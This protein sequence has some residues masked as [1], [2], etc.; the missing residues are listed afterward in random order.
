M[1][2]PK[3]ETHFPPVATLS[4][5]QRAEI[6]RHADLQVAQHVAGLLRERAAQANAEYRF[7]DL[8]DRHVATLVLGLLLAAGCY[9]GLAE[10]AL[11]SAARMGGAAQAQ[12]ASVVAWVGL[13]LFLPAW[14]AATVLSLRLRVMGERCWRDEVPVQLA[15][16][17][18]PRLSPRGLLL[19]GAALGAAGAGAWLSPLLL[20]IGLD[21]GFVGMIGFVVYSELARVSP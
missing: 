14:L 4:A 9:L 15:H 2:S 17:R 18:H 8:M 5:E 20:L 11:R 7:R 1:A 3:H 21:C 13:I 6:L 10:L 16:A 12:A 19:G